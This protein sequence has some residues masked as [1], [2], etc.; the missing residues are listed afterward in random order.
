MVVWELQIV[1][2]PLDFPEKGLFYILFYFNLSVNPFS[3]CWRL[4]FVFER[5]RP[6]PFPMRH[7][8]GMA[9]NPALMRLCK[10]CRG[11][12]GGTRTRTSLS[13]KRILSPLRLPFRHTGVCL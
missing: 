11:T 9:K 1:L 13:R 5:I 7:F 4:D 2:H 12:G 3:D 10:F 8:R 6:Q